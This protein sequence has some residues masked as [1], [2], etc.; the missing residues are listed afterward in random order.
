MIM[1]FQI[2]ELLFDHETE[3]DY[4]FPLHRAGHESDWRKIYDNYF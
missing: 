3:G 1:V 4:R 2:D